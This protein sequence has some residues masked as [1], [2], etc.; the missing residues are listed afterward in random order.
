MTHNLAELVRYRLGQ[1]DEALRAASILLREESL[2]GSVNRSYY[3]MFYGVLALLAGRKEETSKHSGVIAL[4]IACTFIPT[5]SRRNSRNGS[6][7]HSISGP[8]PIMAPR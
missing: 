3:A 2:R 5:F 1:A 7:A 6:G 8:G 4:P